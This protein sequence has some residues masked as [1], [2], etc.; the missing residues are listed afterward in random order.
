MKTK[1]GMPFFPK[2]FP[3]MLKFLRNLKR[4]TSNQSGS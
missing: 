3:A 2:E 1:T 4:P